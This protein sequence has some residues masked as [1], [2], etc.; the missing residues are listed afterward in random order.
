MG[1]DNRSSNC[2]SLTLATDAITNKKEYESDFVGS[3]L[4]STTQ[5]TKHPKANTTDTMK[6]AVSASLMRCRVYF[7]LSMAI[8]WEC[9]KEN[10]NVIKSPERLKGPNRPHWNRH[11]TA[12]HNPPQNARPTRSACLRHVP[13]S[14]TNNLS[15]Q[16]PEQ[17]MSRTR[18][19][20]LHEDNYGFECHHLVYA[21][22]RARR[23]GAT[24]HIQ[25]TLLVVLKT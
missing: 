1:S 17:K 8:G 25:C 20:R 22:H 10:N 4:N 5:F 18:D 11:A 2:A 9:T 15:L 16:I 24:F 6:S 13:S 3:N 14:R 19:R 12:M 7:V 21:K 23:L